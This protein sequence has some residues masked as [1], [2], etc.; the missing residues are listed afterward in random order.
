MAPKAPPVRRERPR[1]LMPPG[2]PWKLVSPFGV[3]HILEDEGAI[4][5]LA[6]TVCVALGPRT[7]RHASSVHKA[8][9]M[10]QVPLA[11]QPAAETLGARCHQRS[12]LASARSHTLLAVARRQ[13]GCE[14]QAAVLSAAVVQAGWQARR[15]RIALAHH[16]H[17]SR[18]PCA[19]RGHARRLTRFCVLCLCVAGRAR[20]AGLKSKSVLP[21]IADLYVEERLA[22]SLRT[23]SYGPEKC[24]LWPM[25]FGSLES[26]GVGSHCVIFFIKNACTC[27]ERHFFLWLAP[28]R[29]SRK[30]F[31]AG[32]ARA[33][34]AD[35]SAP[36]P[37]IQKNVTMGSAQ[38]R[39]KSRFWRPRGKLQPGQHFW[40][41]R[42]GVA[43][44]T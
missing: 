40:P 13:H 4:A 2:P 16:A 42:K 37:A 39:S 25:V 43:I 38:K 1:P 18:T 29:R 32:G 10:S 15:S 28:K 22:G 30:T 11:C 6:K 24:A 33:K 12:P 35:F 23:A 3:L 7:G 44:L 17:T 20:Q 27:K 19:L 14:K 5:L 8:R 31:F 41:K 9:C 34:K 26:V 36:R 21:A